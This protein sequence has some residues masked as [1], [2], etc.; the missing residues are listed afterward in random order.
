[1]KP[2]ITS[3]LAI[4]IAFVVPAAAAQSTTYYGCV[5]KTNNNNL[6]M[7]TAT[8]ACKAGSTR[9]QWNDP[10]PQGPKGDKGDAGP[11][12]PAGYSAARLIDV[13]GKVVGIPWNFGSLVGL[14][15]VTVPGYPLP[16]SLTFGPSGL[17]S[18]SGLTV[19]YES[20]DCSGTQYVQVFSPSERFFA[21]PVQK[22]TALYVNPTEG[23][24][25][26]TVASQSALDVPDYC[27]DFGGETRTIR[28][29]TAGWQAIPVS[30]LGITPPFR[31]VP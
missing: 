18:T 20:N 27:G 15:L 12:G 19:F 7:T 22:A 24:A 23:G 14:V 30:A 5:D 6:T 31:L 13:T 4:A 2:G 25:N 8:E 10:G 26:I 16:V 11:Q 1:M 21:E 9:I 3:A 29:S 28:G 17:Y